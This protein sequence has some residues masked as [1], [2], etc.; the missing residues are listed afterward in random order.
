MTDEHVDKLIER[1]AIKQVIE[2]FD[3]ISDL[4]FW[5][6]DENC[7]FLYANHHF[8]QH[9]G[10]KSVSDIIGRGDYD[11]AAPHLA[12]QF[13]MDDQKVMQ[14]ERVENRLEMNVLHGGEIAWFTTSKRPLY[15]Q[16]GKVIGSY[17]ISRH[18]EKTSMALSGMDALKAPV[19]YVREHYMR[20]ICMQELAS[21]AHLSISALERRFGKYLGKTPTQFINEVRLEHARRLLIETADP[22][23][24]IAEQV[25]F[26]D[27]SYFSRQFTRAFAQ[28]PSL[29]RHEYLESVSQ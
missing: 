11:F 18:L 19:A 15:D 20:A 29:F 16:Q 14:G 12:R 9:L 21:V 3:L 1:F 27:H 25:G 5:V 4:L 7:H 22:V 24:S 10:V 13:Y 23:S 2:M 17:G 8:L 6:K 28:S 26:S